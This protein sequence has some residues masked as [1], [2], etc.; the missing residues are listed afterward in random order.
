MSVNLALDGVLFNPS[1]G[2]G[3]T[4]TLQHTWLDQARRR[5]SG[6]TDPPPTPLELLTKEAVW[7]WFKGLD[8]QARERVR[9]VLGP[10]WR[11]AWAGPS[12]SIIFSRSPPARHR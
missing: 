8:R 6:S 10:L 1:A 12:V 2:V 5:A 9:W 4:L 3:L 11:G 7:V